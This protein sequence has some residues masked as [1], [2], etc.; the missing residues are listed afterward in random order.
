MNTPIA[1]LLV[2]IPQE[3]REYLSAGDGLGRASV[4]QRHPNVQ[5]TLGLPATRAAIVAWLADDE[6][7]APSNAGFATR[8]LQHLGPKAAPHEAPVVRRF[9]LHTSA[10]VRTVAYEFFIVLY[11]PDKNREAL[12]ML[13]N[14]M[15][16]DPE[17]AVRAQAM[18]YIERADAIEELRPFLTL[19][20]ARA[21]Q[22]GWGGTSAYELANRL[23]DP[24]PASVRP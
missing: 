20:R 16:V 19:W 5:E 3:A 11:F 15:V 9:L 14:T 8:C 13:L 22:S 2:A 4:Q 24:P 17:D 1:E 21:Y 10:S 23:L 18:R 12:Y 7:A 6:A